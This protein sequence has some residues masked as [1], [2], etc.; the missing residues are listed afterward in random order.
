MPDET[1]RRELDDAI[2]GLGEAW[3]RGDTDA[4]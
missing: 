1:A 3:A 2:R 4:L